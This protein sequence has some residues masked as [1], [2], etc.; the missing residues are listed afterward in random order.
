MKIIAI[1]PGISVGIAVFIEPVYKTLTTKEPDDLYSLFDKSYPFDVVIIERFS[2]QDISSY[3]LYTVEMV[4]GVT[5]V[6]SVLG[7]PL[8][9]QQPQFRQG[10]LEYAKRMLNADST[11][12]S[13]TRHE[14]DALAH[15]LAYQHFKQK[16]VKPFGKNG[17]K[18][19]DIIIC[20][21]V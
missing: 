9:R 16:T 12:G 3:G 18:Y 6:A 11:L 19:K 1:D 20:Q 4:G 8:V 17:L 13:W 15:L 5:A 14:R 7:M 2:A 10:F 21:N